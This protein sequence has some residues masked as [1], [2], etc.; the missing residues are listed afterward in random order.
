[1]ALAA[2]ILSTSCWIQAISAAP[3]TDSAT[4]AGSPPGSYSYNNGQIYGPWRGGQDLG[5]VSFSV[6]E[7]VTESARVS[8][9]TGLKLLHAFQYPEA[10][11]AFRKAQ[12]IETPND[13]FIMA[14]WGEFMCNFQLL[15]YTKDYTNADLVLAKLKQA[16]EA[17]QGNMSASET[18][19][20]DAAE[21]LASN[22]NGSRSKLPHEA[23]SNEQL[24]YQ[25]L[26]QAVSNNTDLEPE[27]RVFRNLA[28][29]STRNGILDY[30]LERGVISDLNTMRLDSAW[31]NHPGVHHYLIHASESPKLT[32]EYLVASFTA[33]QWLRN[34]SQDG[35]DT[36]SVHL[37]HMPAHFY[38]AMGDWE[39]SQQ[40]NHQAWNKS[41]DRAGELNLSDSSL[42]LHSHLWRNYSLLQQPFA[43]NTAISDNRDLYQRLEQL[44]SD[45]A[46]DEETRV[47]RTYYAFEHAFL[48]L[49]L[50]SDS[51]YRSEMASRELNINLMSGWGLT[52][53]HFAVAW[54]ALQEQRYESAEAS[55]NAL[56]AL[57]VDASL[58]LSP[59]NI[60][61]IPVMV[62]QL[63]AEEQKQRGNLDEAITLAQAVEQSYRSMRWDHGVPLVVK[64]LL[65]YLGDLKLAKHQ[66]SPVNPYK[67]VTSDKPAPTPVSVVFYDQYLTDA[68]GYYQAEL[69]FNPRR[70][71]SLT[72]LYNSTRIAG[73]HAEMAIWRAQMFSAG[74]PLDYHQLLGSDYPATDAVQQPSPTPTAE[75]DGAYQ[76]TGAILTILLAAF[77]STMAL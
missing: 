36:S 42:A 5:E 76:V 73:D 15:W 50:P 62:Q 9:I 47:L 26:N 28:W 22:D 19:L 10:R 25:R 46:S 32:R 43:F 13:P 11:A 3:V 1:M 52:A 33:A 17:Y 49:E 31:A 35:K 67:P 8:F 63:K 37:T 2:L 20:L 18:I 38:F 51:D 45:G 56:H 14:L 41:L 69:A 53:H 48:I 55:R 54:Q 64:P 71:K 75:T 4:P 30:P 66:Q 74:Q 61:A 60:D 6:S 68:T 77:I 16:R 21:L 59:A 70:L 29:L 72:G 57:L 7:P 23:G 44:V 12:E 27:V 34:L 58:S 65:E 24:F 39:N 40:V